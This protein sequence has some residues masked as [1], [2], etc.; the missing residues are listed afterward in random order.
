MCGRALIKEKGKDERKR[1]RKKERNRISAREKSQ[2]K[3]GLSTAVKTLK[4]RRNEPQA[5]GSEL[6][7]NEIKLCEL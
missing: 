3:I 5:R 6:K 4:L 2:R 1:E 7:R